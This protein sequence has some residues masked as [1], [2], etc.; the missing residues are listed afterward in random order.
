MKSPYIY[1][2]EYAASGLFAAY[3]L[4]LHLEGPGSLVSEV[5]SFCNVWLAFAA[6]FFF[7]ASWRR[8]H[9]SSFWQLLKP[10]QKKATLALFTLAAGITLVNLFLILHPDQPPAPQAPTVILLGGGIYKDGS[11]PKSMQARTE[12][13]ASYLTQHPEAIVVVTGGSLSKLP[14]EAPAVKALLIQKGISPNRI[15]VESNA[16]D[17]IQ[18]FSNSLALLKDYRHCTTE[19]VLHSDI[20]V[21][22]SFS[23]LARAQFLARRMGFTRISGLGSPTPLLHIPNSYAREICAWLKLFLRILLTGKP[24]AVSENP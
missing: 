3:S 18:N 11:L 16:L 5:T 20:L 10:W 14:A 2:A 8:H 19:A 17:T 21:V 7:A 1:R 9:K 15:L 23:H 13:A 6:C 24:V 12:T 22:T 4:A